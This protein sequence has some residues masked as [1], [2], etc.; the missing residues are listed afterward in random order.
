M[1]AP[2]DA[3]EYATFAECVRHVNLL[4]RISVECVLV[5]SEKEGTPSCCLLEPCSPTKVYEAVAEAGDMFEVTFF[6]RR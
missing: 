5:R 4:G 1:E 6:C 2:F 3:G